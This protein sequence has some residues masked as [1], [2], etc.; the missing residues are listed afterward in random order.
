MTEMEIAERLHGIRCFLLD[1][2]GTIYLGDKL[3]TFTKS[4]LDTVQK[5]GRAY[6]FFTNNSSKN[7]QAYL[8]KLSRMGIV[9]PP[10][11]MYISNQVAVRVLGER[12]PGGR[13]MVLGTDCLI[14]DF[15]EA[16]FQVKTGRSPD[17]VVLGFDTTITYEAI[18]AACDAVRAGAAFYGVNP[19]WNCP[20]EN[21][22][23][24]PDCGS[25]AKV[26]EASTGAVPEFFGKPA[27]H[28]LDFI[29]EQTGFRPEELAV[30]GD[31]LYTDIALAHGTPVT[32]IL[33]LTGE[34]SRKDS[35][36][37]PT[38]PDLIVE[39]LAELRDA[40]LLESR[41]GGMDIERNGPSV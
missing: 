35:E 28:T 27:R 39:S 22:G 3:F 17:A 34:A 37:A 6:R 18:W 14:Q 7:R 1:M 10:E 23:W 33:V 12:Y 36:T 16:G 31:R 13:M 11:W 5:T 30:I 41:T 29:L 21:G 4:F 24:M 38:P 25:L 32:S 26:I 19:D 8:E 40:L 9:I 2:D 20:V 15:K